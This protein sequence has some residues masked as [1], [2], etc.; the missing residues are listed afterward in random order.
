MAGEIR[1]IVEARQKELGLAFVEETHEYTM[2]DVDGKLRTDFPSV[3]KVYKLFHDE[4]DGELIA[5]RKAR[6][7]EKEK[8]RLLAE[9]KLA[10]D[11]AVNTG[12]RTH[13]YLEKEAV[14][15]FGMN[16][17]L[18]E[19]VFECS[20]EEM[21]RSDAMIRAG[22]DYLRVMQKRGA[23][24]IGTEMVLGDPDLGY[25]GQPD[26][27]WLMETRD[28]SGIGL[29]VTD[30]KTN[31]PEKFLANQFTKR[32]K[33]PFNH[34]DDTALG[35]Y[36]LQ[37]PLYARLLLKML[38]GSKYGNLAFLGAVIVSLRDDG[39]FEEFRVDKETINKVFR[40]NIKQTMGI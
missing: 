37:L 31:K 19:P 34:M 7:D 22:S 28:R 3:S 40:L 35:H 21:L 15:L 16:K 11:I 33:Y 10:G 27:M 17:E 9:W 32:M 6:G 26:K 36:S 4:F 24:L 18:R 30:W 29:V 23:V 38:H 14:G 12:N 20:T 13:F 2:K 8:Q 39:T 1:E 5:S 25:V